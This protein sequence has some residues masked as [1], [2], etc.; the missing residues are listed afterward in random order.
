M[1]RSIAEGSQAQI[2][3]LHQLEVKGTN[4]PTEQERLLNFYEQTVQIKAAS[5]R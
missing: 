1:I 5:R 2:D 3:L 4:L